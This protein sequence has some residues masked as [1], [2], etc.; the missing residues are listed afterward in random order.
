VFGKS[1]CCLVA[2]ILLYAST[3]NG[4]ELQIENVAES[5]KQF[6]IDVEHSASG[7]RGYVTGR[8]DGI[9]RIVVGTA[10]H[11]VTYLESD[12]GLVSHFVYSD[13]EGRPLAILRTSGADRLRGNN[14]VRNRDSRTYADILKAIKARDAENLKNVDNGF[15]RFQSIEP[16]RAKSSESREICILRCENVYSKGINSCDA[17]YE[18]RVSMCD[19]AQD[20]A[21]G[22]PLGGTAA[23]VPA[24][25][26]RSA[27]IDG[28]QSCKN[29]VA[30]AFL[31]CKI[32]CILQP[33]PKSPSDR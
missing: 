25:L 27:A 15:K 5:V 2:A 31:E 1:I 21:G 22:V 24:H 10:E 32:F 11:I 3:V 7:S 16:D 28:W 4:K 26:C 18:R 12:E 13:S 23:A 17:T 33:R 19:S 29:N 6:R 14:V 9:E 30:D 8:G 20:A